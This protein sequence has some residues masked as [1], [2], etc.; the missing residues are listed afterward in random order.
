M[1]A[2]D[3]QVGIA[4]GIV[5]RAQC[6]HAPATA[7]GTG[8]GRSIDK[9]SG[10]VVAVEGI[11]TALPIDPVDVQIAVR[12]R[13]EERGP[14]PFG[15]D[16]IALFRAA[17][18]VGPLQ[19]PITGFV[20]EGRTVSRCA[21][22]EAQRQKPTPLQSRHNL[23]DPVTGATLAVVPSPLNRPPISCTPTSRRIPSGTPSKMMKVAKRMPKPKLAA[24]G[25]RNCA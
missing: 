19:A 10:A 21:G 25:I 11:A 2:G 18:D 9:A 23:Q 4:V 12:V 20:A 3:V 5:V 16:D 22:H 1:Q 24:I 6:A 7:R 15:F 14:A 13:I 17:T 8:R